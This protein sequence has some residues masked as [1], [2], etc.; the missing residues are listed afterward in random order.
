MSSAMHVITA[1]EH[2]V[3]L[4]VGGTVGSGANFQA[5]VSVRDDEL[6]LVWV[7][8]TKIVLTAAGQVTGGAIGESIRLNAT[9]KF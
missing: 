7:P 4:T 2:Y 1:S 9:R 5:E 3:A 8:A 6:G